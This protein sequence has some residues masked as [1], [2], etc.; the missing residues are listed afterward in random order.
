[1]ALDYGFY[2][3][4]DGD[5]RYNAEQ[6]GSI[7]DGIVTEGVYSGVGNMMMVR[8]GIGMQIIVGSGRAWFKGTW[9]RNK[10]DEPMDVPQ[11]DPAFGRIDAV[12]LVVD[13]ND[14][15]RENRLEVYKGTV[16][17]TPKPPTFPTVEN[18]Y[19]LPLAYITVN[20][21]V[22][23][24]TASDI[25]ILV[26]K[27]QCPF[28]TSVLQQTDITQLF[29]KW[30]SDFTQWW[31]DIKGILAGDVVGN[32]LRELDNRVKI[33]DLATDAEAKAG[34]SNS[35]WMSPAR[36]KTAISP[37]SAEIGHIISAPE[38]ST[39][40]AGYVRCDGKR[41]NS[42]TYSALFKKI[43]LK[44][45]RL[46]YQVDADGL[47]TLDQ[48]PVSID[49]PYERFNAP[50]IYFTGGGCFSSGVMGYY[51]QGGSSTQEWYGVYGADPNSNDCAYYDSTSSQWSQR[52]A[53]AVD[54]CYNNRAS[55]KKVYISTGYESVLSSIF[56]PGTG[57]QRV[58]MLFYRQNGATLQFAFGHSSLLFGADNSILSFTNSYM[59]AVSG[60][61]TSLNPYTST[62]YQAIVI[63]TTASTSAT[64]GT[65]RLVVC[66]ETANNNGSVATYNVGTYRTADPP[67]MVFNKIYYRNA[68][69]TYMNYNVQSN[70]YVDAPSFDLPSNIYDILKNCRLR[71]NVSKGII[72][73]VEKKTIGNGTLRIVKLELDQN[74]GIV[75]T[76]YTLHCEDIISGGVFKS[77]RNEL[78]PCV[79]MDASGKTIIV[80]CITRG[81]A[82]SQSLY[83]S[84]APTLVQASNRYFYGIL[85]ISLSIAVGVSDDTTD[86]YMRHVNTDIIQ[87]NFMSGRIYNVGLP[88]IGDDLAEFGTL[89]LQNTNKIS[90][91]AYYDSSIPT[92]LSRTGYSK[93]SITATISPSAFASDG[94]VNFPVPTLG[95]DGVSDTSTPYMIKIT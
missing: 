15:V 18:R 90:A 35:K 49:L 85:P 47:N 58:Q 5:R 33:S 40:P 28:V 71:V 34:T 41:Y 3:S 92:A 37:A 19:Y 54:F 81:F 70:I 45:E 94:S 32:I 21:A 36:V 79:S 30:T 52:K 6:M 22:N 23:S 87:A 60:Y 29:A 46:G 13:K 67:V 66:S 73:A 57:N 16:A 25:E 8:P 31:D 68:S 17:V 4:Y 64:T 48:V 43:G 72:L 9:S 20:P 53:M 88:Y 24:I 82:S 62:G 50:T 11:A 39:P 55:S 51:A 42:K 95:Q 80:Y 74:K 83:P 91:M 10:E 59:N 56:P 14:D 61:Y 12:V 75:S 86:I 89:A 78:S 2:N 7:F 63:G 93:G 1:M 38:L 84:G 76:I 77:V 69:G 44:Y 65:I 27:S 26:G